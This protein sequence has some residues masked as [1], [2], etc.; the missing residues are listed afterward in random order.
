[1]VNFHGK[2]LAVFDDHNVNGV[3]IV[4]A[5]CD[6]SQRGQ[7]WIQEPD[8]NLLCNG[9][10]KCLF[11]PVFLNVSMWLVQQDPGLLPGNGDSIR[12]GH[13]NFGTHHRVLN[14]WGKF[15]NFGS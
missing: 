2:C 10:G 6:P 3:K 4:Q 14:A 13:W 7:L 1:M 5:D 9:W 8:S 11:M 12:G 15:L